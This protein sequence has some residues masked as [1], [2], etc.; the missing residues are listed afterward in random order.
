[1]QGL[2]EIN[3]QAAEIEE[4]NALALAI[5]PA[6]HETSGP[7]NSLSLIEAGGSGWELALVTP[8][9]NNNNN[10]NNPR[11]TIATKLA[12]LSFNF[13]NFLFLTHM[14]Y[15]FIGWRI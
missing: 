11:P 3:P 13:E 10:N 14:V 1:M 12:S 9:N 15:L 7:S 2:N 4:K 8:Q 5:Y 6:G